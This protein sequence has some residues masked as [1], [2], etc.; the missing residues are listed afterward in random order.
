MPADSGG[1]WRCVP[2]RQDGPGSDQ[3]IVAKRGLLFR[4]RLLG[5]AKLRC[6]GNRKAGGEECQSATTLHATPIVFRL[7]LTRSSASVFACTSAAVTPGA[8]SVSSRPRSVTS[9]TAS[10][11]MIRC[12]TL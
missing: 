2:L 12:T 3:E 6:R 10:S 9:M 11:V 7:S 4:S 8:V 1:P 5:T